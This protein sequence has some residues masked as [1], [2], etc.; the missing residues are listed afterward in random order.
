MKL[1]V[2]INKITNGFS[3]KYEI[4]TGADVTFL[5]H[6]NKVFSFCFDC[7]IN[8]GKIM[9]MGRMMLSTVPEEFDIKEVYANIRLLEKFLDI[10]SVEVLN[11]V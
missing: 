8:D 3:V 5:Y 4:G 10:D 11:N 1:K 2:N 9:A 6:D 7:Y